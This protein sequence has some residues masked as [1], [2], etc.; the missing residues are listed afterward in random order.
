M[1]E[2]KAY[3]RPVMIDHVVDALARIEGLSGVA[4]VPT[5]DY[6][7]FTGGDELE[8]IQMMKVEV[9]VPDTLADTVVSTIMTTARTGEGHVGDGTVLISELESGK[10]IRDGSAL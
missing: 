2:I 3:V 10:R 4:I 6:V 1:K 9:D 8:R 5:R 7:H